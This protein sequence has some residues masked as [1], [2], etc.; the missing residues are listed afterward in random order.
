MTP[1][2]TRILRLIAAVFPG[3]QLEQPDG[4]WITLILKETPRS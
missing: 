2:M 4:R 3:T 1:R